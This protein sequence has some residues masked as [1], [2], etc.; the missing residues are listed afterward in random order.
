MEP[1]ISLVAVLR[2]DDFHSPMRKRS[3][4]Q[5]TTQ[6]ITKSTEREFKCD[7]LGSGCRQIE[8]LTSVIPPKASTIVKLKE[9]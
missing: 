5:H 3:S 4:F 1:P 2:P 6:Q 9:F 8:G 7:S